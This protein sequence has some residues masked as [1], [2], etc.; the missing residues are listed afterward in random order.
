MFGKVKKILGIEG[1]KVDI[2]IPEKI[3]KDAKVLH[4]I[5][6]I[7]SLSNDNSIE[8]IHVKLTERY[9]R[10]RG[11]DKLIDEYTMGQLDRKE[12]IT[13]SKNEIIE[14]PFELDFV[15]VQSEMD[16]IGDN[17]F[18]AKGIVF[19]AK[20]ARNVQSEYTVHAEVKVK[21]TTLNP[22]VSKPIIL[23]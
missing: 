12:K 2:I 7:T 19:L 20:K 9:S 4:G 1:A 18:L 22:I 14:V 10:G 13:V 21:G 6:K 3:S 15:F 5:L 8:S 16:R 11:Q 17:N 23:Q